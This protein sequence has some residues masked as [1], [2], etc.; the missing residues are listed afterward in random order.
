MGIELNKIYNESCIQTLNSMPDNFIDLT[1]T[2]PPYNVDIKYNGYDDK[3][4]HL[5]Y[6]KFCVELIRLLYEKTKRGGRFCLNIPNILFDYENNEY[7]SGMVFFTNIAAK[8]GWTYRENITWIKMKDEEGEIFA[9]GKT[10]WGSWLSA[11][12]PQFRS[13]TEHILVFHKET[14]KKEPVGESDILKEEFLKWTKNTWF[15]MPDK[16]EFHPAIF[17]IDIP[18]RC[19]KIFSYLGDLVYEPFTGSGTTIDAC[20]TLKRNYIGSELSKKYYELTNRRISQT[21]LF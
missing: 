3:I 12:N 7:L 10:A 11:S 20:R 16:S 19:I 15:I 1:V 13:F 17:P 2:S 18:Y 9:G 14:P 5:D 21:Q 8:C 6:E 4:S